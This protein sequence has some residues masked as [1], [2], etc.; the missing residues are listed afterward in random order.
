MHRLPLGHI[1]N[2]RGESGARRKR[3][4]RDSGLSLGF[5]IDWSPPQRTKHHRHDLHAYLP[6]AQPRTQ[7]IRHW[8]WS[9]GTVRTTYRHSFA[10]H[11]SLPGN[12]GYAAVRQGW[13]TT[14]HRWSAAELLVRGSVLYGMT[15]QAWT[16]NARTGISQQQW[17]LSSVGCH[18]RKPSRL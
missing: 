7:R 8:H 14:A 11:A 3:C 2:Y 15:H 18:A 5:F 10:L 9:R 4:H 13:G 16:R 12:H 6:E 1:T 17:S